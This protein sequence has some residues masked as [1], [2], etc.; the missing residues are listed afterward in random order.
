[1]SAPQT[2]TPDVSL[3]TL[4]AALDVVEALSDDQQEALLT[5]IKNRLSER[6]REALISRVNQAKLDY[7]NGDVVRGDAA[8]I[9]QALTK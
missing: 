1:M 7:Q 3:V 6:H 5:I 8:E 4:D 9:M 2:L